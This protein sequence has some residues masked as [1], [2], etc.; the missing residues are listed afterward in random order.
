MYSEKYTT[1]IVI[2]VITMFK[3]PHKDTKPFYHDAAKK[4]CFHIDF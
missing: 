1:T 2:I 3:G 4:L